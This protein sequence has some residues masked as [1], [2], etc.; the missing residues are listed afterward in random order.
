MSQPGGQGL[1]GQEP[2]SILIVD[3][4]RINRE[5]LRL[6]LSRHGYRFHMATNGEEA[7]QVL[8]SKA[9]VDLILLDLI[10]PG[11]DGFDFLRWRASQPEVQ[12]VPVIVNSSLDD[13]DSI[14]EALTMDTY[15]Y[16]TK[17]LSQ[18]DLEKVLP[19]KI[20]N[21]V[22]ARRLMVETRR[23]NELLR[24]ELEM[25]ARYQQFLLPRGLEYPGVA[26]DFLFEPCTG[27][28]GDYFDF[29]RLGDDCLALVVADVSGHGVASAMTASI[30]KALLPGYLE[31][32]L[33]PAAA[34]ARLNQ[35]LL[36][37][38]P[39]DVFLTAFAALYQPGRRRL[40]WC[41]AGHPPPLYRRADGGME[42]LEMASPFL[43]AFE[44]DNPIMRLA[45][46]ELPV[47]PGDRLALYTDGLTEAPDSQGRLFGLER[48]RGL[49][50]RH[51][52]ASRQELRRRVWQGLEHF[53]D[54]EF[55]DDVAF[56]VVD[57]ES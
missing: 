54:G 35:D 18:E 48:L 36:R 21:A 7:I 34:F 10:M 46:R 55:P 27:V 32:S 12:G 30:V 56:I 28:G 39:D 2:P 37:L 9:S 44:Q 6:N 50:A 43:G 3:D 24:R 45:D 53:V 42:S 15:D 52:S 17:P 51:G 26:V 8:E 47:G 11:M 57:F 49:L 33:S 40:V 13:F 4:A 38:T 16:F 31:S 5:L 22:T 1:G 41:S 20:K 23:Q 25:A 19:L 14:A 29:M